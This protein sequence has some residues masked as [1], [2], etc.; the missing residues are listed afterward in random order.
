MERKIPVNKT[1]SY[2]TI[3]DYFLAHWVSTIG[4]GPT[5]LYL[6]LLSY[7][8]KGK[9][10]AWPSIQ[11]LNK[12]MG[13]TTKTLIKYRNTLLECGLIKKMVKQRSSSGG[14]EHNLYQIVLLDKENILYPPAEKLPEENEK[15][16][17]GIAEKSPYS[18]Q[19]N[20]KKVIIDNK[21]SL[22]TEKIKE[23]LEKLNLDKK[24]IDKIILNY[25][26]ED[27]EEKL[28][29]LEIKRSVVNPAGWLIAALQVNYLNPESYREE[30]NEEEKMMETK[31]VEPESKPIK[32]EKLNFK[33]K[34]EE[35][36]KRLSREEELEWIRKIRNTVLK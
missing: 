18:N 31:E 4:L 25:S 15:V 7:C 1:N 32:P 30:N 36:N 20:P 26:S 6:Q 21:K 23:K 3:Q 14:Y 2:T 16:I 5:V 10:I 11:T 24:S 12:R 29:L 27:I 22:K 19:D 33:K 13:T 9:D 34:P 28:D 35:E 8:H 17:S